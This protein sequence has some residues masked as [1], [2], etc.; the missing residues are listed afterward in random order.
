MFWRNN[1]Q[2]IFEIVERLCSCFSYILFDWF[3]HGFSQPN[4][5]NFSFEAFR[6]PLV[7]PGRHSSVT[8]VWPE[9]FLN[10]HI[11]SMLKK[12]LILSGQFSSF[13]FSLFEERFAY[14]FSVDDPSSS[15]SCMISLIES[16]RAF[17]A[18]KGHTKNYF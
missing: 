4:F 16:K 10:A 7:K 13:F 1:W 15:H 12:N 17:W 18:L 11:L 5:C 9:L 14:V 8:K 2:S 6:S 3:K